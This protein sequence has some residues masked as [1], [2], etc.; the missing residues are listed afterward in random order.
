MQLSSIKQLS[1]AR[2]CAQVWARPSRAAPQ[3]PPLRSPGS[4]QAQAQRTAA[5]AAA[6]QGVLVGIQARALA[7]LWPVAAPLAS[8]KGCQIGMREGW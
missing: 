3:S 8:C 4:S 2:I 1:G 7:E 6:L 5:A